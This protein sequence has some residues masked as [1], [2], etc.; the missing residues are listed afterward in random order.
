VH[1]VGSYD[2]FVFRQLRRGT[3]TGELLH[4]IFE[5]ADFQQPDD[6]DARI[7]ASILR[8]D[9]AKRADSDYHANLKQLVSHTLNVPIP[10]GENALRLTTLDRTSRIQELEFDFPIPDELEATDLEQLFGEL[11]SRK[12]YTRQGKYR[13]MMNGIVDMF[14]EWEG[15]YYILDWKSNYLGEQLEDYS[16][17][18]LHEAMNESNY[19]L[20]YLIYAAALD[21]Y[22]QLRLGDSYQFSSHFGGVIYLFLRGIRSDKDTGI[23][24]AQVPESALEWARKVD[25]QTN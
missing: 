8:Y 19:H 20:Q 13:G 15:R 2:D 23:Y 6:W 9:P 22:L 3:Q 21:R 1:E 16:H 7:E 14:F 5:Y 24:V 11:D 10:L 18:R 17:D 25:L 12:V 4:R